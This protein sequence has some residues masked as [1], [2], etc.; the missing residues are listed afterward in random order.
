MLKKIRIESKLASLR[1]VENTVDEITCELGI[2]YNN[3]GKILI[4]LLEAV[5]NAIVHGNKLEPEKFVDITIEFKEQK[6]KIKVKD[7]GPGFS[8]E[9]VPDPTIPENIEEVNG[10]GVFI[11]SRLADEIKYSRKGNSVTIVFNN[12]VS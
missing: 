3:Y 11:M 5:N 1:V 9:S 4:T 10:R 6:L 2:S 12:V 7:E 8:P